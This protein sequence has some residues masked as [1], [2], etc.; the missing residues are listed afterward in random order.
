[1]ETKPTYEEL[2]RDVDALRQTVSED[3]Y[4]E[5]VYHSIGQSIIILDPDQNIL[6]AN[7]ATEKITGLSS[8]ELKGKKC[9]QVF[10]YPKSTSPPE[11]CPMQKA[12]STGKVETMEME[13][14]TAS[15]TFLISCTPVF[16]HNSKLKRIIHISA[17]ITEI[18]EMK[19]QLRQAHKMEA[20][21]TLAGGIANEFNNILG[22]IIGNT[23]L[24]IDDVPEWSPANDCLEEIRQ[25]SLRATD[26][27]RHILS[28]ARKS[29][30]ERKPVPMSPIIRDTFKLLRA[31]LPSSIDIRQDFSCEHD[32]VLADPTQINQMLVNLCTNSAHA[33]REEGGV[34]DVRLED[35]LLDEE[36]VTPYEDL[37]PGSYVKLTLKDTGHGI[38]PEILNRIFDP[39]FTTKEVERGTGMGLSVVHGIVKS[40]DGAITVNS[41]VGKGTVVEVL[42]PITEAEI[43]PEVV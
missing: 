22:I 30:I 3:E 42:L 1:M 23:E 6:F 28:F 2:E 10:H 11:S 29:H 21:D 26:V 12:L 17:D 15:G 7:L 8:N 20:I 37:S 4:L 32:T 9:Y 14:E 24:A 36:T 18:I 25:A 43:E 16:D 38:K 27:V 13:V 39:Y 40:H 35:V 34:L 41:E 5:Q 33:M 31:S 19:E